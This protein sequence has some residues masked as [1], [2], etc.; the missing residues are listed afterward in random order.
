MMCAASEVATLRYMPVTSAV[1]RVC[2]R[3]EISEDRRE[4]GETKVAGIERALD[5]PTLS[6]SVLSY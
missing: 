1:G 5:S 2:A 6:G 4:I 3:K